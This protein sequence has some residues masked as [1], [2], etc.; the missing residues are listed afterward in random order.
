MNALSKRDLDDA[1]AAYI[2]AQNEEKIAEARLDNAKIELSYTRLPLIQCYRHIQ[3]QVGD[4]VSGFPWG[5][6]SM[7]FSSLG[8]VGCIPDF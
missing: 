1:N 3:V 7:R 2:A 8:D 6:V 4:Y 5:P